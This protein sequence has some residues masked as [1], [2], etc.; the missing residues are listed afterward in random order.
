VQDQRR[1][2]DAGKEMIGGIAFVIVLSIPVAEARRDEAVV[3]FKD[4]SCGG[5]GRPFGRAN[6]RAWRQRLTFMASSM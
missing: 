5:D 6:R 3:E 4:I 2:R 1:L